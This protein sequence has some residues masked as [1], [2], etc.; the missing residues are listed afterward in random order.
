VCC[1]NKRVNESTFTGVPMGAYNRYVVVLMSK[2][3]IKAGQIM[4]VMR[5][6]GT[7]ING[8]LTMG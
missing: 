5:K 3:G 1:E 2:T 8:E 7:R 4:R 6:I